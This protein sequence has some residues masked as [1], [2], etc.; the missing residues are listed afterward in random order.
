MRMITYELLRLLCLR[1]QLGDLTRRLAQ[2][3]QVVLCLAPLA[4]QLLTGRLELLILLLQLLYA[5]GLLVV[6]LR[7]RL[8]RLRGSGRIRRGSFAVLLGRI[9]CRLSGSSRLCVAVSV[10]LCIFCL[11]IFGFL[12]LVVLLLRD[13]LLLCRPVFARRLLLLQLLHPLAS[14]GELLGLLLVLRLRHRASIRD[15]PH[16]GLSLQ[17]GQL[18]GSGKIVKL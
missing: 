17:R 5:L 16:P 14:C 4:L 6:D 15:Y 2:L 11:L 7:C 18:A 3:S 12:G 10:V 13:G 9:F 8:W 1:P